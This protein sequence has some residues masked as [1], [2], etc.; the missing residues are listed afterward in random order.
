MPSSRAP[1]RDLHQ[2]TIIRASLSHIYYF[3]FMNP[4]LNRAYVYILS[5]K[6]RTVLYIGVTNNLEVRVAQHKKGVGSV[7]TLSTA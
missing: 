2:V 4:N 6:S 3:Y 5:N 7:F 1:T